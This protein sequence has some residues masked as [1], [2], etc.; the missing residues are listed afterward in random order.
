[1]NVPYDFAQQLIVLLLPRIFGSDQVI[2]HEAARFDWATFP[3]TGKPCNILTIIGTLG[4]SYRYLPAR[5]RW[6]RAGRGAEELL[7]S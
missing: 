5:V 6:L 7:T 2:E 4:L 3:I 1:M